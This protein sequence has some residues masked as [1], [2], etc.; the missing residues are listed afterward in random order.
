MSVVAQM[1][2]VENMMVKLEEE[3]EGFGQESSL[4]STA[5]TA[6]ASS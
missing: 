1:H 2:P 3:D 4:S 6:S 5:S